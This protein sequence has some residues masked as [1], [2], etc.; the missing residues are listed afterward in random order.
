MKTVKALIHSKTFWYNVAKFVAGIA[1]A[2]TT[3]FP[4]SH[5][6]G[7]AIMLES[8]I[9]LILRYNTTQ[10]ISGVVTPQV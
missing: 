8:I 3:A 6:F 2:F 4:D 9:A 1:L 10:P 7:Y 5:Y